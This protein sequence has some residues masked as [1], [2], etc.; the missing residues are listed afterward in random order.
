MIYLCLYLNRWV[1]GS[2]LETA[3]IQSEESFKNSLSVLY[4]R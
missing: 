2:N 1:K 4:S 3:D